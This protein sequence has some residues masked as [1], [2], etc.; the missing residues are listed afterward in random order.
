MAVTV[1]QLAVALRLQTDPTAAVAEP[2]LGLLT[3]LSAVADAFIDLEAPDAPDAVKDEALVRFA[4]YAFDAPLSGPGVGYADT[5]RNSGASAM[6]AR[7]RVVRVEIP[8]V[9]SPSTSTGGPGVDQTAREAAA[10]AQQTAEAAGRTAATN[11]GFLSTFADRVRAIVESIV[12]AWARQPSPPAVPAGRELSL[13]PTG[14]PARTITLPADYRTAWDFL[15]L[16]WPDGSVDAEL[17]LSIDLLPT[18]GTR[19]YRSGGSGRVTWDAAARTFTLT[20]VSGQAAFRTAEL[21][22]AGTGTGGGGGEL[23]DGSVTTAKLADDAVTSRKI[24]AEAVT[25][26]LLAAGAVTAS[27]IARDTIDQDHLAANSVGA[28]EL[29]AD[30]VETAAIAADAVTEAKLAAAVR[31]KLNA[32]RGGD[33]A[34]PWAEAGNTDLIPVAKV[35][36]LLSVVPGANAAAITAAVA[37]EKDGDLA[38]GYTATEFAVYGY[39]RNAWVQLASWMRA[40]R[41]DVELEAFI[42]RIVSAWAVAGNADGIPGAKTFDGLFKSE[43]QTPIPAAN[44]TITF[45]VGNAADGDVVDETDAAAS[46]FAITEQQAVETGAFLRCRY[47][48]QRLMLDGFAPQDIEL[49]L[50]T[51]AGVILGKH[52]IKDEGSGAA[53]FP[54]G[55]AGQHRWAVRVVT[56]GRYRGDVVVSETEYHSGQPLADKPIEHIAE[57]A[58]SVEAEKRQAQDA[59]LRAEI[60]RV[61]GI[62][63]IVNGLP[64]A[65]VSRKTAIVW[66]TTPPY[67]QAV[68]DAFQVPATGFVQ[69]VLGNLGATPIM[70]AEDCINREMTGIYTFGRD[71][72]GLEFDSQRRAILVAQR[73]AAL[74]PLANDIAATT[75]GYLMLHWA[76]ARAGGDPTPAGFSP[77]LAVNKRLP[78]TTANV[79]VDVG[80]DIP[81]TAEW[82]LVDWA[83]AG[84]HQPPAWVNVGVLLAL[85]ASTA[86]RAAVAADAISLPPAGFAPG[87]IEPVLGH[88]G[89]RGLVFSTRDTASRDPTPLRIWW[90]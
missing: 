15:F 18:A 3:R 51:T 59:E 22:T 90:L 11:A 83:P 84:N 40:G 41:T 42:E 5:W 86:G 4:G 37:G 68:D 85:P 31:T 17:S 45:D 8:G 88:N 14:N 63:A 81:S 38:I 24:A 74:S 23:A 80:W 46:N 56:K 73:S 30:A 26:G 27:K 58:V 33:D 43:A 48:L 62:K 10:R 61:E 20:G 2:H 70:R 39:A 34:A 49:Q 60:A 28:S 47:T 36:R 72:V 66:K 21:Y 7:W 54:V 75:T 29:R 89:S 9:A 55:D 77:T 50:Q 25:E 44:V 53:T 79:W 1:P 32:S 87:A 82:L 6:L 12:P 57:A 19:M 69:F 78:I 13:M 71:N 65:T 35:P 64:A 52:N 67:E 76:A 16:N